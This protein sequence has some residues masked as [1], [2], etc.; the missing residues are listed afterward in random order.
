MDSVR[1][2]LSHPAASATLAI[3]AVLVVAAIGFYVAKAL[4]PAT[5]TA[6]TS[7]ESLE[8]NFAEMQREGDI[9]DAELRRIKS[10]LGESTQSRPSD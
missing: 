5:R 8:E 6:D 9:S 3:V 1:E 10:V 4:R 7:A 2:V